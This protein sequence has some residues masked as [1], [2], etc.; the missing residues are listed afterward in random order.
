MQKKC[1]YLKRQKYLCFFRK[2]SVLAHE[3]CL[4]QVGHASDMI[5]VKGPFLSVARISLTNVRWVNPQNQTLTSIVVQSK[6]CLWSAFFWHLFC[7]TSTMW[8][9]RRYR[10]KPKQFGWVEDELRRPRTVGKKGRFAANKNRC[11]LSKKRRCKSECFLWW[12]RAVHTPSQL[13]WVLNRTWL[14]CTH[15][16]NINT[17]SKSNSWMKMDEPHLTSDSHHEAR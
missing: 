11:L 17:E 9:E 15:S 5:A 1:P 2:Q 3:K 14:Y 4:F 12:H 8:G 10:L 13:W 16:T 7:R 6:M